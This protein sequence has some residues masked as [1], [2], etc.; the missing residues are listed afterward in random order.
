MTAT[1]RR[2]L[3]NSKL[4]KNLREFQAKKDAVKLQL[5]EFRDRQRAKLSLNNLRLD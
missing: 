3:L 1:E 4:Q 5:K 2:I